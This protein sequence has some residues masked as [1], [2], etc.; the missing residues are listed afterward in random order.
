MLPSPA[1][2]TFLIS[3]QSQAILSIPKAITLIQALTASCLDYYNCLVTGLSV[4]SL[5]RLQSLLY[6]LANL[7]FLECKSDHVILLL[8]FRHWAPDASG[9]KS[10]CVSFR[11]MAIT[12]DTCACPASCPQPT[13]PVLQPHSSEYPQG[14]HATSCKQGGRM[15]CPHPT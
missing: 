10:K 8:K 13:S 4:S 2:S 9:I 11:G 15:P 12:T 7:L 1:D 3:T 14:H 5:A 6:T